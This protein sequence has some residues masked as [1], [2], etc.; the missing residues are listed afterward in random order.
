[1]IGVRGGKNL[2]FPNPGIEKVGPGL[3]TLL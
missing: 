2:G 1:M 3:E